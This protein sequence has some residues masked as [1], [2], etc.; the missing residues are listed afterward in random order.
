MQS[1]SPMGINRT[2]TNASAQLSVYSEMEIDKTVNR[3][4][5]DAT[6]RQQRMELMK[7]EGDRQHQDST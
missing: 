7:H 1:T 2:N 6:L 4:F 5:N 3:L